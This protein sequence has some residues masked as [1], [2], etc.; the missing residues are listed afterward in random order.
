MSSATEWRTFIKTLLGVALIGAPVLLLISDLMTSVVYEGDDQAR[1]LASIADNEGLY[2][3]GNVIGALGALLLVPACM[4]IIHLV[5]VRY[6][7]YAVGAG[8]LALLGVIGMAGM[9]ITF[10]L[11]DYILAQRP[12][13][14][15]MAAV[16]TDGE[17][18]AAMAPLFFLWVAGP[19]GLVLLMAG[20]LRARSVPRW[21]PALAVLGFVLLFVADSG[22]MSILVSVVLSVAL[23]AI[24]LTVLRSPLEAWDEGHLAGPEPPVAPPVVPRTGV[25]TP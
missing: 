9:W 15:I 13:R 14:A 25:A 10:S 11:V 4:A 7:R 17:E 19:L 6:P 18:G 20:L 1:Y 21:M 24:G 8:G 3:S 5:R 23:G 16:L 22:V 12:E 2:Y